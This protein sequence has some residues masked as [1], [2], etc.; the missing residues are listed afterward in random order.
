M[1]AERVVNDHHKL[2]SHSQE[3]AHMRLNEEVFLHRTSNI[4]VTVQSLRRLKPLEGLDD[5]I[6]NVAMSFLQALQLDQM[7]LLSAATEE[8]ISY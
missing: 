8:S 3:T 5:E 4:G 1:L 7:P 6:I 2:L